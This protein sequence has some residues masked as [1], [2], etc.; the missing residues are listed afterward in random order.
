MLPTHSTP[1]KNEWLDLAGEPGPPVPKSRFETCM[2]RFGLVT[3]P[4]FA[5][6]E[7]LSL[8][9]V[10]L[11]KATVTCDLE[12]VAAL[13]ESAGELHGNASSWLLRYEVDENTFEV[14]QLV[15]ASSE[16]VSALYA[17]SA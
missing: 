3:R 17:E 11:Q 1:E 10:E 15:F 7:Q 9:T 8:M 14:K 4:V 2:R 16:I 5:T 12:V 6:N 13:Q